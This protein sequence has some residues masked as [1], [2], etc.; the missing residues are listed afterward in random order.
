MSQI[1]KAQAVKEFWYRGNLFWKLHSVQKEMYKLFY[2]SEKNSTL[3]W[4]LSRQTGKSTLLSILAVEQSLKKKNS[5]VKILTDTKVHAKNIFE[6]IF[7]MI[8][9]DCPEELKPRYSEKDYAY[10]FPNGSVVQLA[11][12]DN[13]HYEKLR[14]QK[15]E[16]ILVDEAGFCDNLEY[17]ISSVLFPTTTHTGGKIVLASTPSPDPD[18]DFL[19]F[20]EK[21][22]LEGLLTK[23]TLFDNPLLSKEQIDRIIKEM[24]GVNSVKFRREYLCVDE[25]TLI[26]TD[27]GY[28][29]IKDIEVGDKVFTHRGRY[30]PVLNKFPNNL[31][32]R[33]VFKLQNSYNKGVVCTEGHKI[34]VAT[35]NYKKLSD[36]Y[37]E[38]WIEVDKI[39]LNHPTK[40]VYTKVPIDRTVSACNYSP[41]LAYLIGWHL[42]EGHTGK[43][44]SGLSLNLKDPIDVINKKSKLVWGKEYKL[45]QTVDKCVSYQLNSKQAS[46]FYNLFGRGAKNKFIP[47][48]IKT[49]INEIRIPLLQGLFSGDGYYNIE[50]KRAGLTSI[51]LKLICDVS[52]MLNSLNISHQITQSRTA[53]PSV[54]LGRNVNV[55]D[56]YTIKIYGQNFEKFMEIVHNIEI[57]NKSKRTRNII[58]DGFLFSRIHRIERIPYNKTVV[59]D[60]EVEDDHSYTSLH[61]TF[62]NCELIK[63][64]V[65]AIIP[66]FDEVAE[67]E[68][69]KEW[70]RPPFFDS[71]V[72]MDLGGRDL[73]ALL[74]GYYDFLKDKVV[75][76]DELI[77]D[78]NKPENTIKSLTEQLLQKEIS[79][80]TDPQTGETKAPYLRVSDIN[81]IVTQEI[82]RYSNNTVHFIN[83]R[84]DD[85]DAAINQLRALITIK[86]II[87]HPRCKT[88]IRHLKNAKW[89]KSKTSFARSPDNGHYDCVDALIYLIRSISYTRNPY[90]NN[91]NIDTRNLFQTNKP[92]SNPYQTSQLS[93]AVEVFK[94]AFKVK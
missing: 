9:E 57:K 11:G 77:M 84:K 56:C 93:S 87:I 30:K 22:D 37:K 63:D 33:K 92:S 25:D 19:K 62:H 47:Q 78:F 4:L 34:L 41:D 49:A 60:I 76:E 55:Q 31:G 29:K 8:L 5:V 74:F 44:Y 24:G 15:S 89:N 70:D 67:K 58:K 59:Y 75:I 40:R 18:H 21:A 88:L 69:V 82:S 51:S 81:Y 71:Y 17:V 27:L 61:T 48:E 65:L 94:K 12:S 36:G 3:V 80:Y 2:S 68:L 20:V 39:N 53:G 79:L 13:G 85:K 73:T 35:S 90:P 16:L 14:G 26:K 64:D 32:D 10:H 83:P 43:N 72:S 54:I 50:A 52:D 28:K 45:M 6:P 46:D 7:K 91:Y 1:S 38:E 23:K 66:E 42:A 86:K